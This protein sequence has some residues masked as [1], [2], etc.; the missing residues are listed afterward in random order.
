M[1]RIL[2]SCLFALVGL[3]LAGTIATFLRHVTLLSGVMAF[4][5]FLGMVLTFLLG[6]FVG[7]DYAQRSNQSPDAVVSSSH[8]ITLI[9]P[10][11][12]KPQRQPQILISH[13]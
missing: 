6:A 2:M 4:L 12:R 11:T 3:L 8:A 9:G 5:V 1:K 13:R 7:F 10:D